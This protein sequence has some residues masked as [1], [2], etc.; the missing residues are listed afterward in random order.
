[1]DLRHY[2]IKSIRSYYKRKL[3]APIIFLAALVIL[4]FIFPI[5]SILS[6][7]NIENADSIESLYSKRVRFV[8]GTFE[9]AYFTG[10]RKRFMNRTEGYYYY[11]VYENKCIILLLTPDT[12]QSGE[13]TLESVSITAK[14]IKDSNNEQELLTKL[15]NDLSWTT[16]GLSNS[17]SV[18]MLSEPDGDGILAKLLQLLLIFFIL[19]SIISLFLS[20]LF[21][22]F[23]KLSPPVIRLSAYGRPWK[24]LDEAE[25]ELETLPQ[26]ATEDMFIT[27]HYFI[28]TSKYGIAI[29]PISEIIWIYKYSTLHKIFWHHFAISYTLYITAK[30]KTY[31][32][33]PKNTKTNIDG[34][35]DYLA[36]ANHDILVG[37]SEE[38]RKKVEKIQDDFGWVEQLK[39]L[40]SKKV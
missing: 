18:Y 19:Y 4:S 11:T 9:N 8:S 20:F 1:M 30:K 13:P 28:E 22:S 6:P 14:I 29:V 39:N 27:Q 40:L 5:R 35:M 38:N 12:C 33:C 23:P 25:E 16:A 37:F 17:V 15:A 36:E 2:I 32:K 34:I 24:M 26:L 10:Y 31:I 21:I 3:A 7:E